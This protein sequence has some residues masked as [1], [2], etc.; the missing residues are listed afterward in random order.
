MKRAVCIVGAVLAV[1]ALLLLFLYIAAPSREER[2]LIGRWRATDD[3]EQI[4]EF[5]FRE[6]GKLVFVIYRYDASR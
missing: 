6:K 3:F 1:I 4:L 2:M 5:T